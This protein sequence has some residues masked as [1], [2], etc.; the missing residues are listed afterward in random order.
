MVLL[1]ISVLHHYGWRTATMRVAAVLIL[2]AGA[3]ETARWSMLE[4]ESVRNINDQHLAAAHYLQTHMTASDRLAAHDVGAVGY[5]TD[6]R[7]VDLPGLVSPA[8]WPFQRDQ[9][10]GWRAARQ[11]GANLFLI[12]DRLNPAL[13]ESVRD[14]LELVT[15]FRVRKPLVSAA[16]TVMSLYRL[17][18]AD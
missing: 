15:E 14:S 12:Y 18:H 11:Q 2:A 16:D 1:G 6:R 10:A 13:Y 3:I 9:R 7:V 17:R 5:L 4:A 8:L